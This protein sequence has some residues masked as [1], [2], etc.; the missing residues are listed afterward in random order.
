[1]APKRRSLI[2][3]A[4]ID[5]L[6]QS[7]VHG[8]KIIVSPDRPYVERLLWTGLAVVGIA[9]TVWLILSTYLTLM[10]TPTVTSERPNRES[11]LDLPFPAVAFCSEN[12]ISREALL[13]YA[14]FVCVPFGV[15]APKG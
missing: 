2:Q 3:A 15:G 5:Y 13:Q 6:D 7:Q 14:D 4:L 12:R 11:V 8:Y 1:M 9:F 10:D